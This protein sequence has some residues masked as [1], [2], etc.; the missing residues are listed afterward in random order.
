MSTRIFEKGMRYI[1]K[2]IEGQLHY[3]TPEEITAKL[4]RY[5]IKNLGVITDGKTN[6]EPLKRLEGVK[7][8]GYY[9]FSL[10]AVST[11]IN[12]FIVQPLLPGCNLSDID[13]WLVSSSNEF[14]GYSL[15]QYL[16]DNSLEKQVII[17]HGKTAKT[18]AYYSYIDFFSN[19]QKTTVQIHNYFDRCYRIPFPLDIRFTLRS[20]EGVVQSSGQVI[21]PAGGTRI[22]SSD[23]FI[24]KDFAGYLEVEFEIASKVVPFLHYYATYESDDFISNNHQSGL[25]LHPAGLRFTR[26]YVPKQADKSLVICLFQ[27]NY[28]VPVKAKAI[29]RYYANGELKTMEKAFPPL[30]KNHMFFQDAKELFP[31]IDFSG[32]S[33]PFILVQSDVPLH[34]P[35]YYYSQ[36][37]KKGY[38]DIS[39]AGPDLKYYAKNLGPIS[40]SDSER[41]KIRGL[42][43]YE[44]ELKQVI[45]PKESGIESLLGLSNDSTVDIKNFTFDFYNQGGK[46]LHSFDGEFDH[47][48]DS[49][50][51]VNNY[52]RDK[53]LTDFSGT[54]SLRAC[55]KSHRV[56]VVMNSISA[57]RH[58][59]NPYLTST[60]ACASISDNIPFYFRGAPPN[61]I[62]GE[63]SCGVTDIFGPGIANAAY[64]TYYAISYPCANKDFNG[65]REYE[66]EIVNEKGHRKTL[67]KSIPAHGCSFLK[68]SEL[69]QQTGHNCLKGYYIVWFF[70]CGAH[71]VGQRI[72]LRKQDCAISVEHCYVGKYGI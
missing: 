24:V 48:K 64:D 8:K 71:L 33:S 37:G 30:K 31:E 70:A 1:G 10:E 34:R 21:I 39:H 44:M 4:K 58:V 19:E 32:I 7:V 28:A 18:T 59:N 45:F 62:G 63:C 29:L 20:Q 35:N 72:L 61:Y 13:G 5:N 66:I 27:R 14:A 68:L 53:G 41:K 67:Y 42:S 12:G 60:A 47:K 65:N 43:C 49:F 38:F 16:L 25:G 56:P 52:L 55:A 17:Q 51:H 54:L 50:L 22:I 2:R 3:Y 11:Q 57:Y 23:D 69:V 26:G 36:R 9:S 46:L 15:N 6:I 40:L